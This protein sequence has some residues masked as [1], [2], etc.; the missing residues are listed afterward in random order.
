MRGVSSLIESTGRFRVVAVARGGREALERAKELQPDFALLD[1]SLPELNGLD[2]SRAIR[3]ECPG[4][5]VL[6]FSMHGQYD[7][8]LEVLKAGARGFVVKADSDQHLLAALDALSIGRPYFSPTVSDALVE[9][10]LHSEPRRTGI[11]TPR[12]REI[13]QLIAEGWINK[14]IAYRLSLTVKTIET[15]RASALRKLNLRTTASLVR[16]ALKNNLAQP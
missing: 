15:H 4:T 13:V 8:I 2:L 7:L 12:E 16:W 3:R 1:Y 14:Q 9:Q 5:E 6:I 11:L 10:Y